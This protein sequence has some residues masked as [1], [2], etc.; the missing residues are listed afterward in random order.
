MGC[1]VNSAVVQC[2][3]NTLIIYAVDV[4]LHRRMIY[5]LA[6]WSGGQYRLPL[7]ANSITFVIMSGGALWAMD[8]AE[9]IAVRDPS[10]RSG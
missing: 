8:L 2:R 1:Y 7:S 10:L 9:R 6:W 3:V 4:R 5:R